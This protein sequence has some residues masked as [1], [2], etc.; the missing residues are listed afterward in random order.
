MYT[1][2]HTVTINSVH[3]SR[4]ITSVIKKIYDTML[5]WNKYFCIVLFYGEFFPESI[6][7][8]RI[9]VPGTIKLIRS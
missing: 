4:I 5:R 7:W 2:A 3:V 1:G 9:D 6:G 8:L